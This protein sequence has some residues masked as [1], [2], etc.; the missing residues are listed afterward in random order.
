MKKNGRRQ[1]RLLRIGKRP[2]EKEKGHSVSRR[3]VNTEEKRGEKMERT[4]KKQKVKSTRIRPIHENEK[5]IENKNEKKNRQKK[6][7]IEEESK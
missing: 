2:H 5:Y 6:I 4:R 3:E 7:S 1:G